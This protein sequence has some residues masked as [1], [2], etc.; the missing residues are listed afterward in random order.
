MR[1]QDFLTQFEQCTLPKEYFKH[2]NHLRIAWLYL[3]QSTLAEATPRIIQ[4]IIRYAT[5]LGAAQIYNETLTQAWIYI[6]ADAINNELDFDTFIHNNPHLLEKDLPLQYYSSALLY[7]E[8]ARQSWVAPDLKD[9]KS[10]TIAHA[11]QS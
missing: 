3:S 10:G 2:I 7:S 5:S 11:K 4:G 9:F 1:D 8:Q 6:V